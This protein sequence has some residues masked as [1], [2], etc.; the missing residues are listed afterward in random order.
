MKMAAAWG[1][2]VHAF[3]INGYYLYDADKLFQSLVILLYL[4][5]V[6]L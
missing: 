4:D 6:S 3:F 1:K 5:I 2:S